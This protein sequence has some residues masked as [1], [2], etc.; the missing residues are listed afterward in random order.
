MKSFDKCPVCSGEVVEKKVGKLF[1][2]GSNSAVLTVQAEVCLHCGGRMYSEETIKKFE[3]IRA[4]LEK[5]DISGFEP[6][7]Q[8]FKVG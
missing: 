6:V 3:S 8:F 7:G 5:K 1:R 2:G 4:K